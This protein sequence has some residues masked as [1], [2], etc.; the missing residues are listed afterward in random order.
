[1][2]LLA[3]KVTSVYTIGESIFPKVFDLINPHSEIDI[4]WLFMLYELMI[5]FNNL[6]CILFFVLL[7]LVFN[8]IRI[9]DLMYIGVYLWVKLYVPPGVI[10]G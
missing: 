7:F 2:H 10:Y 3:P 1:M 4:L 9:Y 6:F 8:Y 5:Y